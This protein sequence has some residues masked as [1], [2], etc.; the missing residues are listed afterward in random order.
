MAPFFSIPDATLLKRSSKP[1]VFLMSG[2]ARRWVPDQSTLLCLGGWYSVKVLLDVFVDAIPLGMDLPSR[3]DGTLL[4]GSGPEV[5]V[6]RG[7]QRCW[8][9]DPDTLNTLGGWPRVQLVTDADLHAIPPGPPVPSA[10]PTL[11][12]PATDTT[13]PRVVMDAWFDYSSS[14]AKVNESSSSSITV[15]RNDKA[16]LVA[17]GE[18]NDGGCQGI[19]I[20]IS[21]TV[22]HGD[23]KHGPS[24]AGWP[25]ARNDTAAAITG[26]AVLKRRNAFLKLD[27][28]QELGVGGTRIKIDAWATAQS[29]R[30]GNSITQVL[31]ITTP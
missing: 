25:A 31:T 26:Q 28:A 27:I 9:P 19:Y 24:G 30:G 4:Q 14:P 20:W 16:L 5:F 15:P 18:D 23:G 8:V 22:W 10:S 29:F 3:A 11:P 1:D 2:G 13:P 17:L 7:C 21:K 12:L 6:M